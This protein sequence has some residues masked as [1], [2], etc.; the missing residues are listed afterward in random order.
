[1]SPRRLC[2]WRETRGFSG[3]DRKIQ[4]ATASDSRLSPR[5]TP[6]QPSAGSSAW[7]GEVVSALPSAPI[8]VAMPV[9]CAT[10][11]RSNQSACALMSAIRPAEMPTPRTIRATASPAKPVD[12]AKVAKPTAAISIST[13][14]TRRAPNASSA[15]PSGNCATA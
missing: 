3:T 12:S 5:K 6:R 11:L 13:V 4:A 7:T 8:A 15:T 10:L 2:G 9:T 14:C 1:M